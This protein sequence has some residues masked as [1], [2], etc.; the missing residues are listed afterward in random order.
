M[1][2]DRSDDLVILT[3]LNE[4]PPAFLMTFQGSAGAWS[5]KALETAF[6]QAHDSGRP[7]VAN[8][9]ALVSGDEVLLGFLLAARSPPGIVLVGPVAESFATRLAVTGTDQILDLHSDLAHAL[10]TCP[11]ADMPRA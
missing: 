5:L 2:S 1:R 7:L 4:D 8:L 3:S 6:T 10:S 11:P 9:S